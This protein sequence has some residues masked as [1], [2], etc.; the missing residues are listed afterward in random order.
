[1]GS[2]TFS[3]KKPLRYVGLFTFSCKEPLRY[4]ESFT[5]AAEE[6]PTTA[7]A[8]VTAKNRHAMWNRL[9]SAAK[10]NPT[11]ATAV[12]I[13]TVTVAGAVYVTW[14]KPIRFNRAIEAALKAGTRPEITECKYAIERPK[15]VDEI[16]TLLKGGDVGGAFGVIL[17][18][19]GTGKT[20]ATR[21]A[22][23]V[24]PSYII[25]CEIYEPRVAAQELARAAGFI[26]EGFL[27][28]I[29]GRVGKPAY[30]IPED[31]KEAVSHVLDTVG[32]RAQYLKKKEKMI[33]P[34]CFVIDGMDLITK[35]D[36]EVFKAIVDMAKFWA[37]RRGL[38]IV[39]VSSEGHVMPLIEST[40][41]STRKANIIEVLDIEEEKAVKFLTEC[42]MPMNLAKRFPSITGNRLVY[43]TMAI[44]NYRIYLMFCERRRLDVNDDD[45]FNTMKENYRSRTRTALSVAQDN[46]LTSSFI[47]Q[48][49]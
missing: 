17:G 41:S 32:L 3:C 23:N 33:F 21:V 12:V 10:E 26:H 34:P 13:A 27:D 44:Y 40:S 6:N 38:N 4:V 2:F 37:N 47:I 45:F 49:N 18:P 48:Q 22:C 24:D 9:L 31:K 7:T 5:S 15:V 36:A 29:F 39:L 1:M 28:V 25:Y 35:Y 11:I 20:H 30:R 42:G 46:S 19:S 16:M 43:L 14:I 8:V